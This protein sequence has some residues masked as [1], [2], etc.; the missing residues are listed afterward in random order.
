MPD[1][2]RYDDAA[3]AI[4]TS[5]EGA[6]M[7]KGWLGPTDGEQVA[8]GQPVTADKVRFFTY[9]DFREWLEIATA[10]ILYQA[11]A[12]A[13]DPEDG[14]VIWVKREAFIRKCHSARAYELDE[15][16]ADDPTARHPRP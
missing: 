12:D 11:A 6:I 16:M 3:V 2:P 10:D 7:F 8:G 4:V 9:R 1:P 5:P 13:E 14:S 15:K